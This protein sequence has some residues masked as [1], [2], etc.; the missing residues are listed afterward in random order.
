MATPGAGPVANGTDG[1]DFLHRQKVASHYQLSVVNKSRLKFSIYL[2]YVLFAIMLVKLA[3][4]IL[5]RLDIFIL[6]LEELYIPKPAL[7]E[8]IWSA[9]IIST[10]TGLKAIRRSNVTDIKIYIGMI[11][12][13]AVAPVLYALGYYLMDVWTYMDTRDITQIDESEV[14]QGYPVGLIWYSF[15]ILASQVHIFQLLF[16]FKLV[17][18]WSVRRK[19]E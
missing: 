17:R 16:A 1:T 3:E 19:K 8:W 4:D 7:W 2:H 9:S 12:L 10:Y 11:L 15:L 14:W 18:F 13:F 6:E 5:D